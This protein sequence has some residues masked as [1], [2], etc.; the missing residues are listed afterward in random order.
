VGEHN[1]RLLQ[2]D[3]RLAKSGAYSQIRN[4]GNASIESVQIE[5]T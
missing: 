5:I 1:L 3:Q 4:S 2:A